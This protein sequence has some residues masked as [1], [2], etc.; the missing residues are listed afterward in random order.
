MAQIV[1]R[2]SEIVGGELG[3]ALIGVPNRV[4]GLGEVLPQKRAPPAR[5]GPVVGEREIELQQFDGQGLDR[6]ALPGI[7]A[8]G[9]P[10]QKAEDQGRQQGQQSDHRADHIARAAGG[11]LVR[12]QTLEQ[13]AGRA[14][15][16]H[17]ERHRA[18]QLLRR[19]HPC[20]R[21]PLRARFPLSTEACQRRTPSGAG[22]HAYLEKSND[23]NRSRLSARWKI[24]GWASAR[25]ASSC[26]VRQCSSMVRRE[27]S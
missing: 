16:E 3:V 9:G 23:W 13:E 11:E 22:G 21:P 2:G 27:N 6:E 8:E 10:D 4:E 25:A 24:S 19:P 5:L 14:A 18:R 7:D 20:L 17:R 12:Q 1:D 15:G 26:P